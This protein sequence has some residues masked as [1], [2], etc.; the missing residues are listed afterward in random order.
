M[1]VG[2]SKDVAHSLG[3]AVPFVHSG[4]W[5]FAGGF[6]DAPVKDVQL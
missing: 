5:F 2:G 1:S 6:E 4:A 3:S